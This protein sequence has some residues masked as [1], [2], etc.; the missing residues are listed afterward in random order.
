VE[1]LGLCDAWSSGSGEE[2]SR[3]RASLGYNPR[4]VY[5]DG[6]RWGQ[7]SGQQRLP[8]GLVIPS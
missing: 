1:E 5:D 3:Q 6:E 4:T 8:S 2:G 7:G